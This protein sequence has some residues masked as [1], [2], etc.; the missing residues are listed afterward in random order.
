MSDL[1]YSPI[2]NMQIYE[3]F[4]DAKIITYDELNKY[5]DLTELLPSKKD[6]VIILFKQTNDSG[7]WV[8]LLRNNND[9]YYFDPLGYRV[10]KAL[11]WLPK[12]LN[13][14]LGQGLPYLTLLCNKLIENKKY[15]IYFNEFPYQSRTNTDI[16]TCGRWSLLVITFF[17]KTSNPNFKKY[18]QFVKQLSEKYEIRD[19]DVLVCK[20]VNIQEK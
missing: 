3:V 1:L 8:T 19:F 13:K 12:Y 11:S 17:Q 7:H 10:D 15:K 14:S 6:Y 2:S 20:L 18:Y 4:P 9:F 16:S 5:N